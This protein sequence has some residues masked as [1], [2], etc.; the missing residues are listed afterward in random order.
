MHPHLWTRSTIPLTA[1]VDS[2]LTDNTDAMSEA[3]TKI[4]NID[5]DGLNQSIADL[6]KA[7]SA[8][9]RTVTGSLFG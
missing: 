2:V 8:L 1:N 9:S 7:V 5:I 3:I 6:N 4:S